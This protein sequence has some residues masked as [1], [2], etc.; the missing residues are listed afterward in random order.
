L[1]T[2]TPSA[3]LVGVEQKKIDG[4]SVTNIGGTLQIRTSSLL[5]AVGFQAGQDRPMKGG[6]FM[7]N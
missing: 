1:V 3:F 5:L 4:V 7:V 2:L 6:T